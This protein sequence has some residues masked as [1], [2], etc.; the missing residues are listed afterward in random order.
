VGNMD[1]PK[2][3]GTGVFKALY[4][5]FCINQAAGFTEG[6]VEYTEQVW[7]NK[8]EE[9]L[10]QQ[11]AASITILTFQ[12]NDNNQSAGAALARIWKSAKKSGF[13]LVT[14]GECNVK[15]LEKANEIMQEEATAALANSGIDE[16]TQEAIKQSLA[17]QEEIKEMMVTKDELNKLDETTQ[18]NILK[19]KEDLAANYTRTI[20]AQARTIA[21]LEHVI[22]TKDRD[23]QTLEDKVQK[24]TY[25]IA[26][27]NHQVT[28]LTS[29]LAVKD[30]A[31]EKLNEEVRAKFFAYQG[32]DTHLTTIEDINS[33]GFLDTSSGIKE[34]KDQLTSMKEV[35][36]CAL[37][38][39]NNHIKELKEQ[40]ASVHVL[41]EEQSRKRK[42]PE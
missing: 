41:L 32:I 3:R 8:L 25:I 24:Q 9:H 42:S 16:K 13:D 11:G 35:Y 15:L 7:S 28:T 1:I 33:C 10:I 22:V 29:Q 12:H 34:V 38:E 27:L 18:A 30:K 37:V 31:I 23:T 26:K 6:I 36:S 5:D 4:S 21:E 14:S 39:T 2:A 40:L 17:M 20:D 19:V